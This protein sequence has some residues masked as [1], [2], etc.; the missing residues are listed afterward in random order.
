MT[1]R[2]HQVSQNLSNA[3]ELEMGTHNCTHKQTHTHK[4]ADAQMP[5]HYNS[6]GNVLQQN[7]CRV[8]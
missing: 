1:K 3:S 7:I 4:H 6:A 8:W 5:T 2:P